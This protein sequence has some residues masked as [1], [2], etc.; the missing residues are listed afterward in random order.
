ME[1]PRRSPIVSE[2]FRP[3]RR[4]ILPPHAASTNQATRRSFWT[5]RG[6]LSLPPG[7][8]EHSTSERTPHFFLGDEAIRLLR[9]ANLLCPKAQWLGL[10]LGPRRGE[11]RTE[12]CAN[13]PTG[14]HGSPTVKSRGRKTV[15]AANA[16]RGPQ[17][18]HRGQ[19]AFTVSWL[20]GPSYQRQQPTRVRS[21]SRGIKEEVGWMGMPQAHLG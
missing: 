18:I 5:R 20:R 1:G 19:H 16:I 3:P 13:N 14:L 2:Q 8:I 17:V 15:L 9:T 11:E 21:R 12:S 7:V 10:Y 6:P 4:S